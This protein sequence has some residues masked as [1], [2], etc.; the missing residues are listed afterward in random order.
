[1]DFLL[2]DSFVKTLAAKIYPFSAL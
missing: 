1:L 2:N